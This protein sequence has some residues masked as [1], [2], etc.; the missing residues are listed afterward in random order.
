MNI[1]K[2][3]SMTWWQRVI[4]K[5]TFLSLGIVIGAYWYVFF[6]PYIVLLLVFGVV[7]GLV[8]MFSGWKR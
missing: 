4:G 2:T 6:Q 5:L 3:C 1:F 7:C 8:Y